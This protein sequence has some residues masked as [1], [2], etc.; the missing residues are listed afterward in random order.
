MVMPI[1][2]VS[3]NLSVE[4]ARGRQTPQ[5]DFGSMLKR[6]AQRAVGVVA[7][8]ARLAA[9]VLPGGS[10]IS[11]VADV[12]S[13][14]VGQAVG[15]SSGDKW[16]LLRAQEQMQQEGLNNSL[17]LLALQRKM[18]E[19]SQTFSAASNVMKVRHEMAKTAIGNI[20]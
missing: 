7:D 9:N 4:P 12:V 16:A 8:G 3:V 18:N 19:E 11:A 1:K 10:F 14:G 13:A 6:G 15:G 2:N 17:R 20:R 5:N